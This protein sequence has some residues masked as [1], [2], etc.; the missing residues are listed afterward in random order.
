MSTINGKNVYLK[1]LDQKSKWKWVDFVA[2][3]H[4]SKIKKFLVLEKED[5]LILICGNVSNHGHNAYSSNLEDAF[6]L[7]DNTKNFFDYEI[8][9][10]GDMSDGSISYWGS[11]GFYFM[12]SKAVATDILKCLGNPPMHGQG[13]YSYNRELK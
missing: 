10:A 13:D 3:E 9:G 11:R 6:E 12:T 8:I 1:F 7:M 2:D 4:L 5:E